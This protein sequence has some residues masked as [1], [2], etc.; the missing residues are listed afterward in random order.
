MVQKRIS[1]PVSAL[2]NGRTKRDLLRGWAAG[3]VLAKNFGLYFRM[4]AD[5][6]YCGA[7]S[8]ALCGY[9]LRYA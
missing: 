3:A 1:C 6:T 9:V 8:W 2:D 4:R 7:R 5:G